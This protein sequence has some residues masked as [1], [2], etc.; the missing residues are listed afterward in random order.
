[1]RT[2]SRCSSGF[3]TSMNWRY[4]DGDAPPGY[5]S[6]RRDR[7]GPGVG[8]VA[9]FVY[10]NAN[11]SH[12]FVWTLLSVRAAASYNFRG[13]LAWLRLLLL[14]KSGSRPTH[15]LGRRRCALTL[16]AEAQFARG[17]GGTDGW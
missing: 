7:Q 10:I 8:V 3:V 5:H 17:R 1:M 9:V 14:R 2:G 12:D 16:A 6:R 4:V 15:H 13:F 11:T